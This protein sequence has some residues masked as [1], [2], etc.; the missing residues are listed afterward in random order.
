MRLLNA[1]SAATL[2]AA[3]A[4]FW[5]SPAAFAQSDARDSYGPIAAARA[6][7]EPKAKTEAT[8]A[9][10][11]KTELPKKPAKT[12]AKTSAQPAAEVATDGKAGKGKTASNAKA[13]VAVVKPETT[14]SL[15][16]TGADKLPALRDAYTALPI[17]ERLAMQLDLIWS[18]DYRGLADGEFSDRLVDA[19]KDYQ[20][21]NKLKVTGLLAPEERASLAAAVAPRQDA[22]GWHMA[23]D[24][25][26]GARVGIPAKFATKV[27]PGSNGTRWSSEQGQLQIE[28]FR[29]DTGATL[30]A[31]FDQQKKMP[32]RRVSGSSLLSDSFVIIGMQGLKKMR[33]VGFVRDGEVRGLTILY[34]QA[35]E[36]SIDPLVMPIS[37]TYLPFAQ[38]LALAGVAEAPRRKVEYGTGVFVSAAGHVLTDRRVVE[39]C[40]IITLPGLG[41]AERVAEDRDAGLALLRINGVSGQGVAPLAAGDD[42]ASSVTLVGVADPAAQAGGGVVS[43]ATAR[44]D[45]NA[46]SL[47]PTPAPGFS[48]AAAFSASGRLAG[49]VRLHPVLTSSAAPAA[50]QGGVVP[51]EAIRRFLQGNN[52]ASSDATLADAKS[53][54]TRVI[55]VR[56]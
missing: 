24:P 12:E 3:L 48:G 26:T 53:A 11:S 45:S 5:A 22:A 6:K 43:V 17:G 25:V 32:R 23:E 13:K 28:T 47:D 56:K 1:V 50:A 37:G 10:P 30:E 31:V 14:G 33:V 54:V 20:K 35:M 21:R 16:A 18:G 51:A 49:V 46:H 34:D 19:V 7:P 41:H 55:C 2:M 36:G 40:Q 9:G 4:S 8:K 38:G 44:V 27:T 39:G 52:V 15:N 29:I 42:D